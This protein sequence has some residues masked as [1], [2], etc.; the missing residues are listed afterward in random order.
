L[1]SLGRIPVSGIRVDPAY[2]QYL[3]I[4]DLAESGHIAGKRGREL[5]ALLNVVFMIFTLILK[6]ERR[7]SLVYL[8]VVTVFQLLQLVG[9]AVEIGPWTHIEISTC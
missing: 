3:L 8:R 2:V 6:N 1:I 4:T 9:Q 5:A 7:D